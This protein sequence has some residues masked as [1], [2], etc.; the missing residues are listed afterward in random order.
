MAAKFIIGAAA[1][2]VSDPAPILP[3]PRARLGSPSSGTDPT[4]LNAKGGQTLRGYADR[5]PGKRPSWL[6]ESSGEGSG[7][8]FGSTAAG[9]L[10]GELLSWVLFQAPKTGENGGG[11][12]YCKIQGFPGWGNRGS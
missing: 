7:S 4:G 3:T 1:V 8:L 6:T 9:A 11:N 2:M 12:R 10:K 5:N